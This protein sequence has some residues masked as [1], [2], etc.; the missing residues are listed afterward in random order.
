MF[1]I[2]AKV[3]DGGY[4]SKLISKGGQIAPQFISRTNDMLRTIENN[5]KFNIPRGQ[6][7]QGKG[8]TTKSAIKHELTSQGGM[9]YADE[10]TA[11]W[12][13]WFE[14]GRGPVVA[15]EKKALRF[16]IKGKPIFAKKVKAFKGTHTMEK[17]AKASESTIQRKA[18]ELG[19]WLERL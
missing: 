2:D 5:V 9:V 12:F 1:Q 3:N 18:E 7:C 4:P 11:P 16:C 14:D 17:G 13:K 8:G 15:K 6:H 10:H 19:K